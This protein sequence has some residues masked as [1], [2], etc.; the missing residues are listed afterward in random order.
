MSKVKDFFVGFGEGMEDFSKVLNVMIN[1]ILLTLVYLI[2]IGF[3]FIS[4]KLFGKHFFDM[5]VDKNEKS[6]WSRLGLKK[7]KIDEYYRQF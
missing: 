1:S 4:A 6:Y 3:T 5:K 7:R 2:G